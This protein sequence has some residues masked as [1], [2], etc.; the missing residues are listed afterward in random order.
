IA[1]RRPP[2]VAF[3]AVR[4]LVDTRREHHRRLRVQHWL[5]LLVRTL[6]IALLV[7][8]AAAPMIRTSAA[9]GHAPSALVLIVDNSPSSAVVAAGV[10]R[11]GTLQEAGRAVLDRATP[12]DALWLLAADG[13]PRRGD[14]ESLRRAVD[15]LEVDP[16]RLDLGQAISLAAEILAN[17]D[18]PGEIVVISDLQATA[19][20]PAD[21]D[22]PLI[23]A[24]PPAE[25][26]A[27]RGVATLITGPQ[28]WPLG[29]GRVSLSLSGDSSGTSVPVTV[30]LGDM[31]GRQ[32]LALVDGI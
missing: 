13:T 25:P 29:G 2:T 18:R 4:Y 22:V 14:A 10:Q 15:A 26:P 5:L 28:P 11:L 20:S 30:Q 8:A 7:L 12:A 24:R 17:D 6:L 27:N 23:V 1:R 31:P 3:P 9:G 32:V 19:L 21:P 16:R